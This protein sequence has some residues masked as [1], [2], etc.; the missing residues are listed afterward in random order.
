MVY[1]SF[2]SNSELANNIWAFP[3]SPSFDAFRSV[4]EV[5][6]F[7][8]YFSNSLIITIISVGFLTIVAAMAAFALA[9]LR[10]PGAKML[11]FV[12]L[13]GLMIPPHVTLIPL[14]SMLRD[15]GLLNKLIALFFPYVGFG[16]PVSIYILHTFISQMPIDLEEAARLDGASYVRFF[17]SILLPTLSPALV[18]VVI[19]NVI[20]IW[21]EYLFSLTF[22]SGNSEAYPLPLGVYSMVI[23]FSSIQYNRAF[24]AFTLTAIPVL[25]LF[26]LMQKRII[27]SLSGTI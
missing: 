21:N 5:P 4:I 20:N 13:A 1:S 15:L 18:T 10:I 23:S 19:I 9:R 8:A 17:W 22:V 7:K 6:E 12:F 3:T 24:S 27:K 14:Y 25:L 2:K 11:L 26:Y 16:L